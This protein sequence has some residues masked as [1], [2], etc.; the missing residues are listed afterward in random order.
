MDSGNIEIWRGRFHEVGE[1]LNNLYRNLAD[2]YKESAVRDL[3]VF[4]ARAESTQAYLWTY[5]DYGI[6]VPIYRTL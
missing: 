2:V 4:A 3:L 6:R 5:I 1:F